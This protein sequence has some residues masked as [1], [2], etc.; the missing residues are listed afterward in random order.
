MTS[1]VDAHGLRVTYTYS[2]GLLSTIKQ[3]DG[4]IATFV[5]SGG[6]L[7]VIYEPGSRTVT[8]TMATINS[9]SHKVT[10]IQNPDTNTRSF[11][12]DSMMHL[13]N[14]QW[15]PTNTTLVYDSHGR[16]SQVQTGNN[17]LGQAN[18][19]SVTA[20]VEQGISGGTSLVNGVGVFTDAL[21]LNHPVTYVMDT[22]GRLTGRVTADG[23]S[24]TWVRNAAGFVTAYTDGMNHTTTFGY[25]G[26]NNANG[27]DRTSVTLPDGGVWQYAFDTKFH[28][29][30]QSTDP[31]N[32]ITTYVLNGT[33]DVGT[34][35]YANST[36]E[37]M[38][39]SNG[40][41]QSKTDQLNHITSYLFDTSRRLSVMIDATG[42]R[43][44][45]G[46][47]PAGNLNSITDADNHQTT[48]GFD[49]MRRMIRETDALGNFTTTT[50]NALG[51]VTGQ[52]DK[53]GTITLYGY[54]V[55]G[56]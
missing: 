18:N 30:I 13:T 43:T 41:L 51:E 19:L 3:P 9:N 28:H 55:H 26:P 10:S 27:P 21:P 49:G 16:V 24:Q 6:L 5:Y 23:A 52:R 32:N 38:V 39:W 25:S 53:R 31:R 48:M 14:D 12:Y 22:L 47:D 45:Y 56:C 4:A 1:K 37:T 34:I 42:A 36:S 46:Y 44:T 54:D 17:S 20:A 2:S 33:G 8:V 15:G 11:Q 29:L 50:Y 40:L 7:S 35:L